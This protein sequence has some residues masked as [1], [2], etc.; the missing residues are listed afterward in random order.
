[1]KEEGNTHFKNNEQQNAL[2]KYYEGILEAKS[3]LSLNV[4]LDVPVGGRGLD[5]KVKEAFEEIKF[6]IANNM[7]LIFIKQKKWDKVLKFGEEILPISPKNKKLCFRLCSAYLNLEE[8][9]KGMDLISTLGD[10]D[11]VED[12]SVIYY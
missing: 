7:C 5:D 3:I 2:R 4:Q 8:Y 1:M 12:K 10:L 6:A 9:R 11:Q